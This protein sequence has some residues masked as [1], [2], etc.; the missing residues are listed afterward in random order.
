MR[1]SCGMANIVRSWGEEGAH[2]DGLPAEVGPW[3]FELHVPE[4]ARFHTKRQVEPADTRPLIAGRAA[5][6]LGQ[7]WCG[8]TVGAT[9]GQGESEGREFTCPTRLV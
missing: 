9:V 2:H 1:D 8:A 4:H 6:V 3:E 7:P 5:L